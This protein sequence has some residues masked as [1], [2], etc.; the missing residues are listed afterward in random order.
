MKERLRMKITTVRR[1]T[2]VQAAALVLPCA[3]CNREVETVTAA[4]A[5]R[6][7]GVD[8]DGLGRLSAAGEIHAIRTA[9]GNTWVCKDS[10]FLRG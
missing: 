10:L 5:L 1:Q 3:V 2:L 7:L 6:I 4:E 9:S 8:P